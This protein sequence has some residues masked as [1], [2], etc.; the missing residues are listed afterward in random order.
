MI[1]LVQG[2]C[3]CKDEINRISPAGRGCKVEYVPAPGIDRFNRSGVQKGLEKL[4]AVPYR[5]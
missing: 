5:Y 3:T 2:F 4:A 1:P